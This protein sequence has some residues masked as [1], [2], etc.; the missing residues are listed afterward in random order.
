MRRF[1]LVV[2]GLLAWRLWRRRQALSRPL[3]SVEVDDLASSD[4]VLSS[5]LVKYC[6]ALMDGQMGDSDMLDLK[7][8]GLLAVDA[9]GVT[10][11]VGTHESMNRFWWI[12]LVLLGGS[13]FFFYL[14]IRLTD[15]NRGPDVEEFRAE[16][17]GTSPTHISEAMLSDLLAAIE[18]NV[19]PLR[20]KIG[21]MRWGYRLIAAGVVAGVVLSLV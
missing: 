12:A 20:R 16:N 1:S 19:G 5:T 15:F 13:S 9:A 10:V 6:A 14:A 8:L 3:A 7:A 2:G 17:T 4:L 11:L 21:W 18:E